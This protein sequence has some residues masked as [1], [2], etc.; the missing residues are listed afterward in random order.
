MFS[1]MGSCGQRARGRA[2]D[3]WVFNTPHHSSQRMRKIHPV[4]FAVAVN[5]LSSVKEETRLSMWL[6]PLLR[7]RVFF[8]LSFLKILKIYLFLRAP[9]REAETQAEGEAGSMQGAQG[10][11]RSWDPGVTP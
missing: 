1:S 3:N 2:H 7:Q 9:E 5:F 10:G 8:F 6:S 11:T 4:V